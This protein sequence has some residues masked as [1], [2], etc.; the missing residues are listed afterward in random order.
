M[1]KR[2]A[3]SFVVLTGVVAPCYASPRVMPP[4]TNDPPPPPPLELGELITTIQTSDGTIEAHKGGITALAN[5]S[6]SVTINYLLDGVLYRVSCVI[7]PDGTGSVNA[8][9]NALNTAIQSRP[10][11]N[12][13]IQQQ[14]NSYNS[15]LPSAPP[16]SS[17]EVP[18][19]AQLTDCQSAWISLAVSVI[20][21]SWLGGL[22]ALYKVISA[23]F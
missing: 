12:Q 17:T 20:T 16:N 22:W 9:G 13:T 23:C 6:Y 15:L 21:K 2:L 4:I 8:A 18:K 3:L 1:L 19:I 14:S 11:L 10:V 7:N 5:G